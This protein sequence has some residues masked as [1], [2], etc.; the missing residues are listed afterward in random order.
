VA[1]NL[2]RGIARQDLVSTL[3][4]SGVPKAVATR[5]IE[6]I[7]RSPLLRGA[8]RIARLVRRHALVSRLKRELAT[9]GREPKKVERRRGLSRDEF[10][11]RYYAG[12]T[13]VVVTDALERWPALSRWSPSYFKERFGDVEVEVTSGRDGD[14]MP[15]VHFKAHSATTRLADFCD[16]V[17]TAGSS[18]DIYLIA[19]NH[20]TKRAALAPLFEDIRADHEYL[21]DQRNGNCIS[22]WFGPAG[23][24][25][26]LHHDTANVFLCQVLGRKKV[27]LFPPF[28]LSLMHEMHHGVYSPIDA[29]HPEIAVKEVVLSPGEA[30]FI[31]VSWWH[32]VRSLE[33]SISLAFTN[34]RAK[35][36]FEWYYPGMID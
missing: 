8:N 25:T 7:R 13:P 18:N 32:H 31:P 10:F 30:L 12:N 34:F 24:V 15:D 28:E 21:D 17:T 26:P 22:M 19:N 23:T 9:L 2:L 29:E 5:E 36:R 27:L 33:V 20:A 6:R 4:E 35:N 16:R 11:D 14:P 3:S 1:E